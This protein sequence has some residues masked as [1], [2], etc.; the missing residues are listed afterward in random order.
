MPACDQLLPL[1]LTLAP[2]TKTE[3]TKLSI[4]ID[5]MK[6]FV[7]TLDN[8][9]KQSTLTSSLLVSMSRAPPVPT[10]QLSPQEWIKEIEKE[11]STLHSQVCSCEQATL[12][13]PATPK[14]F[15]PSP[16]PALTANSIPMLTPMAKGRRTLV[17]IPEFDDTP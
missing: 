16:M 15:V 3:S 1:A 17:P 4:L 2:T 5:T 6:Q 8:Q 7:A 13:P 12:K 11:L 9:S 14:L 10:F